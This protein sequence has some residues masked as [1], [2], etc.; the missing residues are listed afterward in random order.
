M[1]F[2]DQARLASNSQGESL[3]QVSGNFADNSGP[4]PFW[5]SS[6]YPMRNSL[7]KSCF[8]NEIHTLTIA[9]GISLS[10]DTNI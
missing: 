8:K 10:N 4:K 1:M 6:S 9:I 5:F 2:I 7:K 3:R